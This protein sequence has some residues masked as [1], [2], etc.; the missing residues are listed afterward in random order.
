MTT[1]Q[2]LEQVRTEVPE[3]L[4]QAGLKDGVTDTSTGVKY[5]FNRIDGTKNL[6]EQTYVI[7]SI[8][9]VDVLNRADNKPKYR[10]AYVSINLYTTANRESQG[11]LDLIENLEDSSIASGWAFEF[12]AEDHSTTDQMTFISFDISKKI[13]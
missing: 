6:K 8:N 3:L 1:A 5:Y 4:V 11:I 2:A 12:S 13:Q 9:S 10:D 7:W